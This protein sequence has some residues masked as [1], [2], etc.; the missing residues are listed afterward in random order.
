MPFILIQGGLTVKVP[1][2][3][4][5]DWDT[6][7]LNEFATPISNHSHTGNGDGNQLGSGSIQDDSMDDRKLRLRT[8]EY[9]RSRNFSGAGDIDL[10]K[11]NADDVI[12]LGAEAKIEGLIS[13]TKLSLVNNQASATNIGLSLDALSDKALYVHYMIDRQGTADL[14]EAGSFYILN[15]EGSFTKE[16]HKYQG[17]EAGITFS[18]DGSGNIQYIST[19]NTGSTSDSVYVIVQRFGE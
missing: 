14:F 6:E 5:T 11:S 7:F 13:K 18:V 12:E 3:G 2:K 1:T 9:F 4:T 17:D 16:A 8:N 10:I 15:K 19:D